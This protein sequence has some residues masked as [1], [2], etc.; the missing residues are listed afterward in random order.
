MRTVVYVCAD[1]WQLQKLRAEEQNI[2]M[3]VFCLLFVAPSL[4]KAWCETKH[5]MGELESEYNSSG[6]FIAIGR[7]S[8][9]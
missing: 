2:V 5:Q 6:N 4:L 8:K 1:F 9:N 3:F 7:T